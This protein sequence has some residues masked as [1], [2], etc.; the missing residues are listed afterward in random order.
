MSKDNDK[1][2]V[3]VDQTVLDQNK[4]YVSG[5]VNV[6]RL[7]G[8]V[9]GIKKV[10]YLFM[11]F[12]LDITEQLECS[13]IYAQHINT[14]LLNNFTELKDSRKTYDIFLEEAFD[15]ILLKKSASGKPMYNIKDSQYVDKYI[16]EVLL[17]FKKMFNYSLEVNKVLKTPVLENTRIHYI[18]PRNIFMSPHGIYMISTIPHNLIA[19]VYDIDGYK[20]SNTKRY[21]TDLKNHWEHFRQ[22]VDICMKKGN[23]CDL[24][25]NVIGGITASDKYDTYLSHIFYKMLY[26]YNHPEIKKKLVSYLTVATGN[27]SKII[28]KLEE[29]Y[30]LFNKLNNEYVK[31]YHEIKS[32]KFAIGKQHYYNPY[33]LTD[34]QRLEQYEKPLIEL[35]NEI[36]YLIH[37]GYMYMDVFFL[38]R[39]LDKDYITNVIAYTGALHSSNYIKILIQDF[40]FKLTHIAASN[41]LTVSELNNKIKKGKSLE[42]VEHM[43]FPKILKQCS[44][45]TEF[46]ENFE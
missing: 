33:T 22:I 15:N 17:M 7:E 13:N 29:L 6:A 31:I 44:D 26:R 27:I 18:D 19:T 41:D 10:I 32:P 1:D 38:R 24:K 34:I 43:I 4:K 16:Y 23:L 8:E 14:Y 21:I 36:D 3:F 28:S 20:A 39:F 46:P 5:P 25:S 40:G 2:K 11:D 42:E 9:N 12:H 37:N 45:L 35:F 30:E